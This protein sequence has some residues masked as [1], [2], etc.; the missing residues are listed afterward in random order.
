MNI[1]CKQKKWTWKLWAYGS[2]SAIACQSFSALAQVTPDATLGAESSL[3]NSSGSIYQI[4]GG[5]IRGG[6]LFHSFSD[7][8]LPTGSTAYFNNSGIE[9]IIS[10]VT[11]TAI[12]HID[13]LIKANG[14]SNLFL[15][16]PNGIVFG[17]NA[18][19]EIGGSFTATTAKAI[20][21]ADG[22]FFS[23]TDM[24]SVPLLTMSVPVGVQWGTGQPKSIINAGNLS[25]ASEQNLTLSA[26]TI[27][28]TGELRSPEGNL[29]LTT[30]LNSDNPAASL[31]ELLALGSYNPSLTATAEGLA[32]GNSGIIVQPGNIALKNGIAQT[33]TMTAARDLQLVESQLQTSG[34]LQ[35]WAKHNLQVRDSTANP[36]LI[37]AGG[38]LIIQG[39]R[40]IDI[41]AL[42][43]PQTP[44]V[45][46]GNLSLI[47]DGVISGDAH[48]TSGGNFTIQNL[49]G[50]VG[51]FLSIQDPIISANGDVTFGNYTGAS[52]KVE[53]TGSIIATGAINIL[54]AD[55]SLLP[56]PIGSDAYILGSNPSL[57][58]RAGLTTLTNSANIP[59]TIGPTNFIPAGSSSSGKISVLGNIT[60]N[61]G[62]AILE[63][64]G[65]INTKDI[66]ANGG[67]ITLTSR[68]GAIDTSAGSLNSSG[69]LS[70]AIAIT[71]ASNIT[72]GNIILAGAIG[73]K[74]L[75]INSGGTITLTENSNIFRSGTTIGSTGDIYLQAA[76]D[77]VFQNNTVIQNYIGGM[78]E[79]GVVSLQAGGSIIADGSKFSTDTIG[80][81][82]AGS[83]SFQ[84]NNSITLNNT[85]ISSSARGTANAGNVALTSKGAI[86]LNNSTIFSDT[87]G[88]GN[89]GNVLFQAATNISLQ[90]TL[91]YNNT[92][93]QSGNAGNISLQ[94]NDT[95]SLFGTASNGKTS[96]L[97][98]NSEGSNTGSGGDIKITTGTLQLQDGAFL[99]ASTVSNSNGGNITVNVSNLNLLSG[100]Q[101]LATT[102]GSGAAGKIAVNVTDSIT[103]SG[104]DPTYA[105]RL[106]SLGKS[107][108]PNDGAGSIISVLSTGIG[109]A[110]DI[111]ITTS[112]LSLSNGSQLSARS[113]GGGNAGSINLDVNQLSL[114]NATITAS[115][116]QQGQGGTININAQNTVTLENQGL[117]VAQSSGTG[118]AGNLQIS[119]GEFSANNNSQVEV[120]SKA[121]GE[122]GTLTINATKIFLDNQSKLF[123]ETAASDGGNINLVASDYLLMRHNSLI[124]ASAGGTGNGGNL[125]I[126]SSFVIAVPSENSDITA[127]AVQGSGGNIT[128][129]TTAIYGLTY[130]A[131][132]TSRSDITASSAY[133]V[134]GTVTINALAIDP[135]RALTALP[136]QLGKEKSL[137][138]DRCQA[139]ANSDT[140]QFIITG[141]GG[142]PINP[143]ES[144]NSDTLAINW[145]DGNSSGVGKTELTA[146]PPAIT[147]IENPPSPLVE[148]QGLQVRQGKVMLVANTSEVNP[149]SS[150]QRVATCKA[151]QNGF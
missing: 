78:G 79:G 29:I 16:N 134:S 83:V 15:I 125:N 49:A 121:S 76:G 9:N 97:S 51:D 2:I 62:S 82:N 135:S 138:S 122:G 89:A 5:A 66:K 58:L 28:S 150:W 145:L 59:T 69:I 108:V 85:T 60:T 103:I 147:K 26:G 115:T 104:N 133:G 143:Y 56:A 132:L 21:F 40:A 73:A 17:E 112:T 84:A 24:G 14:T 8:S 90:G 18:K 144:L 38:N 149:S 128:I 99:N 148:A 4:D 137:E 44:F 80:L 25:V 46:A 141:K 109:N 91:I 67:N 22:N 47:S 142:L 146:N 140:S 120:S 123:A 118:K 6:N 50:G 7:F 34:N 106:A 116:S 114:N 71:A 41:L 45:S 61:G 129:S 100:G 107:N 95:I 127:N 117:I 110:G 130:R 87:R 55:A 93:S 53:A 94:A 11:G 54:I 33:A 86:A 12:S 119:T 1:N 63:A 88:T 81:G 23:A 42:N 70:D 32:M 37:Q 131:Q 48:F 151:G 126:N 20:K 52:L 105:S 36:V 30:I 75:N 77:I 139:D 113:S 35:L 72:L 43:H 64:A 13:G 101:I 96:G 39:D 74:D 65:N 102:T 31:S 27:V 19:L 92:L 57:I 3:V 68:N 111:G 98:S 10:R 124:S 136:S